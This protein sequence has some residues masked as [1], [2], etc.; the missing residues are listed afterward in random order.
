LGRKVSGWIPEPLW[1][2]VKS[3]VPIACVDVIVHNHR[4]TVLLGWRVIKPY[5]NVWATPGGR[6][7]MGETLTGTARRVLSAHGLAANGFY[8]VG[9]FPVRF[10]SRFDISICLA[11][12]SFSGTPV[13]DGT[14]FKKIGWFRNLPKNTGKNYVEMIEKWRSVR[15]SAHCMKLNRI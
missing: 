13:P 1:H 4:G 7:R 5:V 15:D 10:P 12:G 11:A 3:K 6:I 8:L 9:V 14:E 2:E